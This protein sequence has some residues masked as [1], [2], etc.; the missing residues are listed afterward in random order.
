MKRSGITG[1]RAKRKVDYRDEIT[2]TVIARKTH[3]LV[4]KRRKIF[5]VFFVAIKRRV[6]I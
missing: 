1:N 4:S 2:I 5:L 3:P 6:F